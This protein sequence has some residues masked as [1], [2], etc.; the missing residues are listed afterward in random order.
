VA[1]FATLEQAEAA[2][3]PKGLSRWRLVHGKEVK[4]QSN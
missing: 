3:L 4:I 1:S 2:Y